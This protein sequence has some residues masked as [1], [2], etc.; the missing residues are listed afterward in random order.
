MTVIPHL[1]TWARFAARRPLQASA[2]LRA[3]ATGAKVSDAVAALPQGVR[4]AV[5]KVAAENPGLVVFA[6]AA[7]DGEES[8]SWAGRLAQVLQARSEVSRSY[9]AK[10]DIL[11]TTTYGELSAQLESAFKSDGA[12]YLR[13]LSCDELEA[14]EISLKDGTWVEDS[15]IDNLDGENPVVARLMAWVLDRFPADVIDYV[16]DDI[17]SGGAVMQER[18]RLVR[19]EKD[20]PAYVWKGGDKKTGSSSSSSS[21]SSST[22]EATTTS[23]D[24]SSSSSSW[25]KGVAASAALGLVAK[26]FGWF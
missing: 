4:E 19:Q 22:D 10:T 14:I 15:K 5:V 20:C 21:S 16:N 8:G 6:A 11:D 13:L 9:R 25:F 1:R 26:R 12:D 17:A 18:V 7:V 24:A 23:A 2:C 3:L